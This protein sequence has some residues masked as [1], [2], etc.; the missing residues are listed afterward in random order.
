MRARGYTVMLA[1]MIAFAAR[2][3]AGEPVASGVD[4]LAWLSGSWGM[5][6]G[7][8]WSEEHWLA[9]RGGVMLGVGRSG[10]GEA[11]AEFEFLRIQADADGAV[12]YWAMP[13]GAPAVPFKRVESGERS[14]VFE[15]PAHDFPTRIAYRRD[16]D[17]LH[18]TIS[19]PDGADAA[20]WTWQRLP[21]R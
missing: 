2:A 13:G 1:A 3:H 7:G 16:G 9:P 5:E 8:R 4:Q 10:K 20:S 15:N 14:V 17:T 11:S 21:D 6:R 19:G 12:A 18:A